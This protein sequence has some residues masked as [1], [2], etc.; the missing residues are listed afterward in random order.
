M[1]VTRLGARNAAGWLVVGFGGLVAVNVAVAAAGA[2]ATGT[3]LSFAVLLLLV[4]A[5][6]ARSLRRGTRWAWWI[7]LALACV[8][9]FFVLPVTGTIL[10][11]GSM[12][13]VG[14]GWDVVFFPLTTL[15]LVALLALLW[16]LRRNTE[17]PT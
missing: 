3:D 1:S 11:G 10:L 7:S 8:G 14:T 15:V 9:L 12:E 2:G 6:T 13:P 5:V 17:T 16:V 4:A